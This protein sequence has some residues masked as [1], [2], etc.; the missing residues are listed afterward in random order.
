MQSIAQ[1]TPADRFLAK[2]TRGGGFNGAAESDADRQQI[3]SN[4]GLEVPDEDALTAA[5]AQSGNRRAKRAVAA[6]GRRSARPSA[7]PPAAANAAE[8]ASLEKE[9]AGDR[10]YR[11]KL[12]GRA[13]EWSK[14]P[15]I[16]KDT[17]GKQWRDCP[18]QVWVQSK[19]IVSCTSGKAWRYHAA[20]CRNKTYL[21]AL[22]RA[23]FLPYD[24][25]TG[26]CR[27][28]FADEAARRILALGLA[29]YSF[30]TQTSR[31]GPWGMIVRGIPVALLQNLLAY[32]D[33][34]RVPHR[35]TLTGHHRG[36]HSRLEAGELGL[37]RALEACGAIARTQQWYPNA[38]PWEVGRE[39]YQLNRYW[40]VSDP[41]SK[42]E[43]RAELIEL[44]REGWR[45]LFESVVRWRVSPLASKTR[46]IPVHSSPLEPP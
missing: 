34:S 8:R 41:P 29:L 9:R 24:D 26:A 5:W 39:G 12:E 22:R 16:R 1:T 35:N 33:G 13:K 19:D 18:Q 7:T 27:R 38:A 45:S 20:R 46:P 21:G 15:G 30:A 4:L 31:R 23:A 40:L 3:V 6:A 32:P 42:G 11:E 28:S 17:R 25:G 10:R 43:K 44:N 37:L 2:F 36:V 14:Q